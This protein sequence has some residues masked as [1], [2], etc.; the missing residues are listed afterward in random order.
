[1]VRP[2]FWSVN[3]RFRSEIVNGTIIDRPLSAY[4]DEKST[5]PWRQTAVRA[6]RSRVRRHVRSRTFT[7]PFHRAAL[8]PG[9][10][11]AF[12]HYL[13]VLALQVF[14]GD[15]GPRR[16]WSRTGPASSLIRTLPPPSRLRSISRLSRLY[17]LPCSGD[18][19]HRWRI[20]R[21]VNRT[22]QCGNGAR[23]SEG[24]WLAQDGARVRVGPCGGA[25]CATIANSE[26]SG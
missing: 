2:A 24:V 13:G 17:D 19:D 4:R 9:F 20:S 15:V 6:C 7:R 3:E 12:A 25:L 26:V 11:A 18:S 1:M 14:A 8:G 16:I 22:H 23:R 5:R 10:T 21:C